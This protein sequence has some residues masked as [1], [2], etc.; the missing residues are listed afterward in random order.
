M[1][2]HWKQIVGMLLVGIIL[3]QVCAFAVEIPVDEVAV[4]S[5]EDSFAVESAQRLRDFSEGKTLKDTYTT[6]IQD[7]GSV[8]VVL[9][10]YAYVGGDVC[11]QQFENDVLTAD[12]Y[13][14]HSTG[15]V[16]SYSREDKEASIN[17]TTA[18]AGEDPDDDTND[19]LVDED[20]DNE[21]DDTAAD[22]SEDSVECK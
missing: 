13:S 20:D 9:K 12:S 6:T 3:S 10:G 4:A 8:K 1:K 2:R 14:D 18:S 11:F 22:L 16:I 5:A 7:D 17:I 21:D 19:V 15:K